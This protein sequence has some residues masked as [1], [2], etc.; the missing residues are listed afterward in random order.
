M[1][2]SWLTAVALIVL[3]GRWSFRR[4]LWGLYIVMASIPLSYKPAFTGSPLY[5]LTE[6]V[7]FPF[8]IAVLVR[9][10][11]CVDVLRRSPF[12]AFLPFLAFVA[13]SALWAQNPAGVIKEFMRWGSFVLLGL[14]ASWAIDRTLEFEKPPSFLGWIGVIIS[15]VGITQFLEGVNQNRFRP[16]AA[17]FL[18]HPNPTA[19]FLS[20]CILP[21]LGLL[22]QERRSHLLKRITV[23]LVLLLGLAFTFSRG[24]ILACVIGG[25]FFLLDVVRSRLV[26]NRRAAIILVGI[27]MTL[28]GLA[29]FSRFRN[30]AINRLIMGPVLGERQSIFAFG[31]SIYEERPWLGLGAGNLKSYALERHLF[32]HKDEPFEPNYGD[33]HNL[34]LQLA[35]ET[36]AIGLTLFLAGFLGFSVIVTRRKRTAHDPTEPLYRSLWAASLAYLLANCSGFYAVKGIHLEWAVLLAVQAAMAGQDK[37]LN[38]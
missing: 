30:T 28:I 37:P 12:T 20:L 13:A 17:A 8:A 15:I 24:V 7:L 26:M 9:R 5:Y 25:A 14:A 2:L 21:M 35:V 31:W 23:F 19:A 34:F 27:V 36:G 38:G 33:L 4:P 18:G 10:R 32:V 3:V 1:I 16:G 22:V 11:I 6:L 29:G